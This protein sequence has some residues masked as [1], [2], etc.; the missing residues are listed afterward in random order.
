MS[1]L[2]GRLSISARAVEVVEVVEVVDVVEVVEV[3]DV[4]EVVEVVGVIGKDMVAPTFRFQCQFYTIF[5]RHEF[6]VWQL[7]SSAAIQDSCSATDDPKEPN[8]AP[9]VP[10][11]HSTMSG[12]PP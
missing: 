1:D 7:G 2:S 5:S 12:L 11:R 4:V 6:K 10:L 8:A 9:S 3:V